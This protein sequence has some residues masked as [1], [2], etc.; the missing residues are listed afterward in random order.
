MRF[1]SVKSS[2][3]TRGAKAVA[4]SADQAFDAAMSGKPDFTGI[5]KTA[6]NARSMERQVATEAEGAVANAAIDAVS[7]TKRTRMKTDTAKEVSDIKRPAKR[8]AGIVA[9]LGAIGQAAVAHKNYKEDK[10]EREELRALEQSNFNTKMGLLNDQ[11]EQGRKNTEAL[12]ELMEKNSQPTTVQQT[13]EDS[14]STTTPLAV[15]T[16]T[17]PAADTS[18]PKPPATS[19][20]STP[21]VPNT[22]QSFD[23]SSLTQSDYEH[24]AYAITS[25]AGGGK[26]KY[27]VAASILNRVQ[28]KDWP[29]TVKDVIFQDGQ[30]EGIYKGLSTWSPKITKDLMSPQGQKELQEALRVLDGRTDFKGQTMLQHRSRKGNKDYDGDGKPDLDPMFDPTGNFFHYSYQT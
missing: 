16:S 19:V 11:I 12:R 28:S 27:G 21:K 6:M 2:N 29:G 7:Q 30:Y 22:G 1:N 25:E 4:R 23:L 5:A 17:S 8:M 15:E 20:P 10:R 3:F 26:D 18:A 9:G 24:L 13:N 14:S